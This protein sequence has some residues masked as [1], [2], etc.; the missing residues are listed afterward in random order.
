M[1]PY[2]QKTWPSIHTARKNTLIELIQTLPQAP[3]QTTPPTTPAT[4]TF[5]EKKGGCGRNSGSRGRGG[6]GWNNNRLQYQLCGRKGHTVHRC[7]YR[8]D[9]SYQ[10]NSS[11]QSNNDSTVAQNKNY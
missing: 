3:P 9:V 5:Q 8:F 10:A 11:L 6:H 4:K 1:D 7:Y 2:L